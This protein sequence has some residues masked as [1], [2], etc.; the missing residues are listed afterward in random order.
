VSINITIPPW[1]TWPVVTLVVWYGALFLIAL[2]RLGHMDERYR[3]QIKWAVQEWRDKRKHKRLVEQYGP[4]GRRPPEGQGDEHPGLFQFV[5]GSNTYDDT[6]T[7]C[8]HEDPTAWE[9]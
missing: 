9:R 2:Y 5:C 7:K 1:I 4:H 3:D 8:N 6:L